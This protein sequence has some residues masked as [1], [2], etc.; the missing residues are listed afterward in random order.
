MYASFICFMLAAY[1]HLGLLPHNPI[2]NVLEGFLSSL[3]KHV[4]EFR[5]LYG[6]VMFY[7]Y[8]PPR[9]T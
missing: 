5:V 9:S 1:T 6:C 3:N 7:Y 8:M 2:I 4:A